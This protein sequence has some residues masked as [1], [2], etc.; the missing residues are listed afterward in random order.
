MRQGWGWGVS[1]LAKQLAQ[2]QRQYLAAKANFERLLVR[3]NDMSRKDLE[4]ARANAN[5][6]MVTQMGI[7]ETV[8]RALD[9]ENASPKW[10]HAEEMAKEWKEKE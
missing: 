5:D 2:V 3:T 6:I 9:F 1:S 10:D 7:C 4:A 8:Q